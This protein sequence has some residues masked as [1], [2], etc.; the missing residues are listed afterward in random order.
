M[1]RRN[2]RMFT[3]INEFSL[4]R[5]RVEFQYFIC[6]LF[7]IE[8]ENMTEESPILSPQMSKRYWAI[9]IWAAAIFLGL[10]L[11][12]LVQRGMFLDGVTYAAISK[13]LSLGDG[14]FWAP[15]YTP[16]L[17]PV[18]YEHPPLV[19]GL[20]SVL[21]SVFGDHFWI[22]RLYSFL[23]AMAVIGGMLF[24]LRQVL[25]KQRAWLA[26]A[27]AVVLW[28]SIPQVFWSFRNNML[29][30][31]SSVLTL[32]SVG[33]FLA[34]RQMGRLHFCLF[35][36]LCVMGAFLAKG[37]TAL[38][39]LAAPLLAILVFGGSQKL[40]YS[41][42]AYTAVLAVFCLFY[43]S[44]HGM[45]NNLTGY[46]NAQVLP[47]LEGKREVTTDNRFSIVGKFILEGMLSSAL[48]GAAMVKRKSF[49]IS[50]SAVFFFLVALSASLPMIVSLKQRSYYLVPAFPF[51]AMAAAVVVMPFAETFAKQ[52]A[53]STLR[54]VRAT[55]IM[56]ITA[57]LIITAFR[58][59]DYSRN[60]ELIQDAAKLAKE[61]PRGFVFST[62]A[63]DWNDWGFHASLARKGGQGLGI[64]HRSEYFLS[65]STDGIPVG[66]KEVEMGLKTLVLSLRPKEG[67]ME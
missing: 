19:F 62:S 53:S 54:I 9:W 37:P 63:A 64:D 17:Y 50:P 59:G 29:E 2:Q 43:F 22:E 49:K 51:L 48:I 23:T 4:D 52:L 20:Q 42:G 60:E 32:F 61:F 33:A 47:A 12:F 55:G 21:F 26:T 24:C 40:K 1:F 30:N 3:E 38:F 5:V 8:R 11:P 65:K 31:T 45:Q 10:L 57:I 25:D 46:F 58:Y 44:F 6:R 41:I 39:P 16:T 18:F 28:I 27:L 35:G 56:A 66:Y 7:S 36:S 67:T 15:H 14:S 13:N 34:Y